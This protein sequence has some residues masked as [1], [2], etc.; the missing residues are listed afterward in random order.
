MIQTLN[1]M[2]ASP[3]SESFIIDAGTS[4]V[5]SYTAKKD[6]AMKKAQEIPWYSELSKKEPGQVHSFFREKEQI[7]YSVTRNGLIYGV[8]VPV[9]DITESSEKLAY[10]NSAI[11]LALL[12]ILIALIYLAVKTFLK[13]MAFMSYTFKTVAS[14]DL[15]REAE[16]K[17][18]DEVGEMGESFNLIVKNFKEIIESLKSQSNRLDQF[19]E[20]MASQSQQSASSVQEIAAS[21]K[22]VGNSMKQQKKIVDEA[23]TLLSEI[24]AS[25]AR[26]AD[27]TDKN[28][29]A[30]EEA[31]AAAEEMGKAI[32]HSAS[33]AVEGDKTAKELSVISEEGS[34]LMGQL[35]ETI[36]N[37]AGQ[38]SQ[39]TEMVQLIMDISEQ[40]NL[41]AMN[42][43]I[44]AAHAGEYGKGFAV[45]AEEIRK[46]ADKSSRSARDIQA[47]VKQIHEGMEQNRQRGEKTIENFKVL[48]VKVEK[49]SRV[50][51]DIASASG[52][53]K[54]ANQSI[55]RTVT[56]LKDLGSLIAQKSMEE[57]RN[58]KKMEEVFASLVRLSEEV[59]AAMEEEETALGETA[60]ASEQISQISGQLRTIA[61]KIQEDFKRFKTR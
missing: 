50:N 34:T 4:L 44:E 35:S 1:Q 13:P 56:A 27:E 15:T 10:T 14:G 20:D 29:K 23:G 2:K 61:R 11:A 21:S 39:I 18:H 49:S 48:K 53:Q 30:I 47:V 5:L 19:S 24:A 40:T 46:L 6:L 51:H 32:T 12:M 45:V 33:L 7:Y 54:Q 25:I 41:L 38:S 37:V 59:A 16:V 57:S 9:S 17:S 43:A 3:G 52:E 42:A 8:E 22:N 36:E 31:S 28:Q 58:V 26:I 60:Q 55:L